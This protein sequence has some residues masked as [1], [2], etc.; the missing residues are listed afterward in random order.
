[1][2]YWEGLREGHITGD[3]C[4]AILVGFKGRL[5]ATGDVVYFLYAM[6]GFKGRLHATGDV[7]YFLYAILGGFKGRS[8]ATGDVVYFLYAILG[9]FKGRLHATANVLYL[10]AF[11][12]KTHY[13]IT[14]SSSSSPSLYSRVTRN[15]FSSTE[16]TAST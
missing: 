9:G 10:Y 12:V 13:N 1:M 8:H 2:L 7:V 3:V 11:N 5:H 6:G 14:S 15:R 4:Y 16:K